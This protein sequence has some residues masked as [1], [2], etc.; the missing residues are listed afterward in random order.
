MLWAI[1]ILA[2]LPWTA[3]IALAKDPI[4][5]SFMD[6]SAVGGY[7]VV[8]YYQDGGPK[9]GSDKFKTDYKGAEWFF[10]TKENLEAFVAEPE[11]Y[12]PQ[13]GGYCAFA[14][15]MNQTVKG[16]PLQW[17]FVEDKLYLNINASI[18]EKWQSNQD[19]FI[20]RGDTN[21]PSLLA[22]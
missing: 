4:Y 2:T 19:E 5:T 11:K 3:N 15:A 14:V 1:L 17:T 22:E 21:W 7:D 16:D 9:K 10:T 20:S 12:A 18:K 13:Y 8:S 6:N